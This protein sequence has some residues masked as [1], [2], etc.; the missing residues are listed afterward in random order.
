MDSLFA[1]FQIEDIPEV[2]QTSS[3]P[4]LPESVDDQPPLGPPREPANLEVDPE[5][6]PIRLSS[7]ASVAP[8]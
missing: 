5:L 8:G 3:H 2:A 7:P 4:D 1:D 6:A